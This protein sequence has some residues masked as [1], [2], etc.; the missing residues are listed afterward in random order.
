MAMK[1]RDWGLE[2][3][4]EEAARFGVAPNA[5]MRAIRLVYEY[6]TLEREAGVEEIGQPI[7]YWLRAPAADYRSWVD[8]RPHEY[9]ET[10]I[11]VL[12]MAASARLHMEHGY[13][14]HKRLFAALAGCG[15]RTVLNYIESGALEAAVVTQ[16]HREWITAASAL[17]WVTTHL[18]S[19]P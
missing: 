10:R 15:K 3:Y 16:T 11:G 2:A 13:H 5:S 4:Q 18:R 14:V 1:L 19:R 9:P 8:Y 17:A 6:A 12:L 7:T